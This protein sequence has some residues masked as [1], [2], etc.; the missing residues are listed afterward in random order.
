MRLE[1]WHFK[2][3]KITKLE[4][5]QECDRDIW[6]RPASRKQA[7]QMVKTK[8]SKTQFGTQKTEDASARRE[9]EGIDQLAQNFTRYRI[10]SY[11][12][13]MCKYFITT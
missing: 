2:K 9:N 11:S 5:F 6:D 13:H 4:W 1:I 12:T 10:Q 8:G 3:W 7:G